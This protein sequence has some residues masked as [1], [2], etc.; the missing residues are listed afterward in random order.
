MGRRLH[1][2]PTIGELGEDILGP[3]RELI[4]AQRLTIGE[5]LGQQQCFGELGFLLAADAKGTYS[6]GILPQALYR[7][8]ATLQTKIRRR[9][10]AI[11]RKLIKRFNKWRSGYLKW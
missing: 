9:E 2:A 1:P 6:T 11:V 4:A 8:T 10:R 3:A 5:T 7:G